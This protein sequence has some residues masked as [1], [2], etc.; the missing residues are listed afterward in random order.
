MATQYIFLSYGRQAALHR[1]T[2]GVMV[3]QLAA[4]AKRGKPRPEQVVFTDQP[5]YFQWLE[6]PD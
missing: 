6:R 4:Y 1:Q 2:M 5:Q 3:S